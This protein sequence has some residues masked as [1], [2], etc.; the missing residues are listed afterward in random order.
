MGAYQD[1]ASMFVRR[2]ECCAVF[3]FDTTDQDVFLE[4][5]KL[6][7]HPSRRRYSCRNGGDAGWLVV[8][9][10]A[11]VGRKAEAGGRAPLLISPPSAPGSASSGRA[12][13][14]RRRAGAPSG[15]PFTKTFT[16]KSGDWGYPPNH[17]CHHDRCGCPVAVSW[18]SSV[19]G[20]VP[21]GPGPTTGTL[22]SY[23]RR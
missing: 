15:R 23:L 2:G 17:R 5:Q 4:N 20:R 16:K 1:V 10:K 11:E 6:V 12:S 19:S 22:T 7:P 3:I 13:L 18:P 9:R 21:V 14:S 8:S